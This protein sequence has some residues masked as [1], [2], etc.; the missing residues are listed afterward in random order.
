MERVR[1]AN[2]YRTTIVCI[3]RYEDRVLEGRLYNPYLEEGKTF[4]SLM[5]F[6]LTMEGLLDG[7]KFPQRFDAPRSFCTPLDEPECAGSTDS[8]IQTG[9]LAT[10]SVRVLFRQ[11]ASW[12]GSV[13]WLEG[14]QEESFRSVL[15]LV[16]LMN[17]ALS[18][19]N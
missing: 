13:M 12:Q 18:G 3:D 1:W 6:L 5:G 14:R 11:N 16:L 19:T 15:E 17:T 2:E 10:F 7:M 8:E 4:R 9:R